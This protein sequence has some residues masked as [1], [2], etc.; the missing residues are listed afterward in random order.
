MHGGIKVYRGAASAAR[1]YLEADRSRADDYYLAEG[2][3]IAR[4]FTA[5]PDGPALELEPLSGDGYEAWVAGSD[6]ATGEP[7]GRLRADAAAVRFVEVVVNGPKSWSLAAELH[8][9]VAV[10]FEV[11]QDRAASQIIGWL[12]QHATTRVGP[13]GAQVAVPVDR[14]EAVT[15][16]HYTSRAGDPHRHLHLQV[17]ARVFA[18]GKWRGIDTVAV[19]D[20]IAAVNGIGHA[21][22]ACDPGFRAALAG[23]GYTLTGDGEITQLAEYVGPF[24]KRATQIGRLIDRYEADWRRTHPGVEPGPRLRRAWDAR[25]WAEDRPDKVIPRSGEQLRHRWLDELAGLGYRDRD[26]PTQLALALP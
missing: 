25:A 15:V 20:S 16:R 22:V 12:G 21:A 7:R 3:G 2:A 4:R 17:N 9:D 19:R 18:A 23:H 1:D 26:R 5:G 8:P 13:R 14:L 10:A 24:S 6:P 11:A